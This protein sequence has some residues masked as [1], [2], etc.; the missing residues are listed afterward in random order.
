MTDDRERL[1]TFGDLQVVDASQLKNI[2]LKT[3]AR[4]SLNSLR[5]QESDVE[6]YEFV[7][8]QISNGFDP[9]EFEKIVSQNLLPEF[10]KHLDKIV[11]E[12]KDSALICFQ[13][14]NLKSLLRLGKVLLNLSGIVVGT[15]ETYQLYTTVP[16]FFEFL[17]RSYDLIRHNGK[18]FKPG[19]DEHELIKQLFAISQKIQQYMVELLA[20]T[21]CTGFYFQH[22]DVEKEFACLKDVITKLCSLGCLAT[23]VDTKLSTEAWKALINLCTMYGVQIRNNES[24]WLH[25]SMLRINEEIEK[26]FN[27]IVDGDIVLDKGLTIV[28]KL[29]NLLLKVLLKLLSLVKLEEF[30]NFKSLLSTLVKIE[31]VLITK[32][33]DKTL[34]DTIRQYLVIGYM[35]IVNM[36]YKHLCFAKALSSLDVDTDEEIYTYLTIVNHVITKLITDRKISSLLDLYTLKTNILRTCCKS[37]AKSHSLFNQQPDSYRLVL[38]HL[39]AFVMISV[40][41]AP[42]E[43]QKEV[44]KTL[45][46]MLLQDAYWVGVIGLDIWSTYLRCCS[47][48]LLLQYFRFWKN[49]YDQYSMF[50]SRPQE[51]FVGRLLRNIYLFCP[52][53]IQQKIKQ[54]FAFTEINNRK[55]WHAVGMIHYEDETKDLRKLSILQDIKESSPLKKSHLTKQSIYSLVYS[56]Q[57]LASLQEFGKQALEQVVPDL[58]Y[59]LKIISKNIDQFS[60]SSLLSSLLNVLT[61]CV[62][63]RIPCQNAVNIAL[64]LISKGPSYANNDY[65]V[66]KLL[67][68]NRQDRAIHQLK[69]QIMVRNEGILKATAKRISHVQSPK[70]SR[71]NFKYQLTS[72]NCDEIKHVCSTPIK[73]NFNLTQHISDKIDDL[74]PEGDSFDLSVAEI[75]SE[76]AIQPE[77]KRLKTADQHYT[78][79]T[80]HPNRNLQNA[81]DEIRQQ[82]QILSK[83]QL[84]LSEGQIKQID[85]VIQMLNEIRRVSYK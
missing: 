75:E 43:R 3:I 37:I 67:F 48:N 18:Q 17:V 24:A 29:D 61:L 7:F 33:L 42:V 50:A 11:I 49:I 4:I 85:N 25:S 81:I 16:I 46:N 58:E 79:S 65:C 51:V 13:V 30:N 56:F 19:T 38:V 68:I 45:T 31:N 21:A 77:T 78:P 53:I 59:S 72:H 9:D 2:P 10:L 23:K 1:Q 8:G 39:T 52:R 34:T 41:Q 84:K 74:F 54:E 69:H 28:L 60:K 66:L 82:T 40:K 73:I 12:L 15:A 64:D 55:M 32:K 20:P 26:S 47:M 62:K 70:P 36:A 76:E 22:V 71:L 63:F 83:H 57:L 6:V 5:R 27:S 44:E 80:N 14:D 35:N